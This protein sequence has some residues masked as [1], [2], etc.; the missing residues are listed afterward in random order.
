M[1]MDIDNRPALIVR[2]ENARSIYQKGRES[3]LFAL[4]LL[5]GAAIIAGIAAIMVQNRKVVSRL[6]KLRNEVHK[7]STSGDTSAR[8]ETKGKDELASLAVDINGMLATIQNNREQE[9][10]LLESLEVEIKKRAEYTREL[11]HELKSPITPIL[12]SSELLIEEINQEPWASLAKNIHRGAVDMNDRLDDLM[13][14]ARGE[15][16]LLQLHAEQ[17][18][19]VPAIKRIAGEMTPLITRRKQNLILKLPE[20]LRR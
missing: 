10:K 13:D 18:D 8:V 20:V 12:S 5:A 17:L 9:K 16:G 1:V 19:L 4:S 11:I 14:T 2:S 6:L 15:V 3:I 7:I